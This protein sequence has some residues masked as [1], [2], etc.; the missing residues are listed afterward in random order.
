MEVDKSSILENQ[1][2]KLIN[3]EDVSVTFNDVAG[4]E[5]AKEEITE[6]VDFKRP[7]EIHKVRRKNS[8]RSF[9]YRSPRNR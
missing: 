8:K 7:T 2:A 5:G 6:I 1:K 3:K 9:T 4:L